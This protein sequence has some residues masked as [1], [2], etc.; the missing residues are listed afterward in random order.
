MFIA[1][2]LTSVIFIYNLNFTIGL[3]AEKL[4]I[5]LSTVHSQAFMLLVVSVIALVNE[6]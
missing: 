5:G 2:P 1:V 4:C 3:C 6:R